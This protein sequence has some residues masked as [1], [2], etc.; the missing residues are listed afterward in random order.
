MCIHSEWV[1][2]GVEGR[3]MNTALQEGPGGHLPSTSLHIRTQV[4][5]PAGPRDEGPSS[6]SS[7]GRAGVQVPLLPIS[8]QTPRVSP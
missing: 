2:A 6:V 8:R 1:R 3:E 5:L 7:G 4:G